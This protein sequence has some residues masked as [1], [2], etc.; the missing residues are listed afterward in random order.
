MKIKYRDN[1]LNPNNSQWC[2]GCY[3]YQDTKTHRTCS[4][5]CYKTYVPGGFNISADYEVF[6]L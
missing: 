2:M 5:L 1:T 4:G 6:E 3:I